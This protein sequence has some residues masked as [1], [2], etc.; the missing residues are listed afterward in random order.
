MRLRALF[1]FLTLITVILVIAQLT[2]S[3][4]INL[5]IMMTALDFL[6]L[7]A[8]IE[9]ERKSH[10]HTQTSSKI[11]SIE[12]VC[13]DIYDTIS[14]NPGLEKMQ[15]Q[16]EDI[17]AILDRIT[18]NSLELEERINRFGQVLSK[19]SKESEQSSGELVY[20]EEEKE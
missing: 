10:M 2:G 8:S 17:S 15:K 1:L 7:G 3:N 14:S 9:V 5:I 4:V 12:K 20:I 11:E 18:K 6:A 16:R 19:S 13:K